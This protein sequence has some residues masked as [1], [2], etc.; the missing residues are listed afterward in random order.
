MLDQILAVAVVLLPTLFAVGIEVVSKEI[1]DHLYWRIAVLAFGVGLSA[2]TWFQMSRAARNAAIE[3]ENA[4]ERTATKVSE[5]VAPKVAA[6][7]SSR[8][9][10]TLNRDYGSVI[11]G[12]YQEIGEQATAGKRELALKFEPSVD[13]IY[14]GD[15]LQIWNRGSTNLALWGDKYDGERGDHSG[16]PFVISPASNRYLLT[17]KLKPYILGQ[18]GQNGEAHVPFDLYIS[19]ADNQKYVMHGELWEI[20]K[21]G[22]ITIHTQNHG[23][24]KR[25]WS[26][27]P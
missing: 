22:Q 4:I 24:E 1:K 26:K 13:L 21:D 14:A 8:V 6:E 17:D 11:R 18:L 12:L 7:T 9:T 10:E 2:L 5:Q 20:V 25:D 27:Q 15:Q 3:Q 19:T 16:P 23:F